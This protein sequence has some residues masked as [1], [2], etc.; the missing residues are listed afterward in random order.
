MSA[1]PILQPAIV[2]VLWSLIV[3]M[4]MAYT[5]FSGFA[6]IRLNLKA[7]K[8]GGRGQDLE[9]VLPDQVN[10]KSHNYAHLMEQPTLF[11][12]V[13]AIIALANLPN[14]ILVT[15]AW[16]Y[17]ILRIAH[18]LWQ[19]LVNTIPI[20]FALFILSTLCLLAMAVI[21]AMALFG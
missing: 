6:K 12:A 10:W 14:A 15:L 3:L 4:W 18:S 16:A 17:V 9:S 7:A 19:G 21:T 1:H 20:R 2:L 11:Y 8:P 5:R 13:V